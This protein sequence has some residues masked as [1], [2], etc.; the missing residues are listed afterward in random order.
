MGRT[1]MRL[2]SVSE[3]PPV[4]GKLLVV[5]QLIVVA[6]VEP[7]LFE[8]SGDVFGGKRGTGAKRDANNHKAE[9]ATEHGFV[10]ERVRIYTHC[11]AFVAVV[12]AA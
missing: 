6:D 2:D 4:V 7:E 5:G 10:I 11:S 8:G 12:G 3:F 1:L 9:K